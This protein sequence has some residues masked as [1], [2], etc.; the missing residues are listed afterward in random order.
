MEE[1]KRIKYEYQENKES[2]KDSNQ[3]EEQFIDALKNKEQKIVFED[4]E[5]ASDEYPE[6]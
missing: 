4:S 6:N 5:E 2:L 3:S 1:K